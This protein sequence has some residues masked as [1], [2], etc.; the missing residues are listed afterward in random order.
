MGLLSHPVW[1]SAHGDAFEDGPS[2]IHRGK[3][4]REKLFCQTVPPL[5][6][7]N[8]QAMLPAGDGTESARERVESTIETQNECMGCHQFMNSL[9]KPFEFFNH[10]GESR[11][12]T[13]VI[14]PMAVRLSPMHP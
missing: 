11:S 13:M 10:A 1:L 4:V 7:V 5:E 6:L 3:W 12:K 8:V 14:C 2:L 9:G